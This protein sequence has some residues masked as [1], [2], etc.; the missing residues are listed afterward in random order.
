MSSLFDTAAFNQ[1]LFFPRRDVSPTPA[2]A[3][4]LRVEVGP[5]VGLH[6][7][8]HGAPGAHAMVLLFHGNG[9]VVADYDDAGAQYAELGVALAVVDYRG[10]GASDWVPTLRT[11]LA[12]AHAVRAAAQTAAGALPVV[13]MGRSLGSACAA[14]LCDGAPATSPGFIFESAIADVYGTIRR[15]G[16]HLAGPLPEADLAVFDPLRKYARCAA[17]ALVLHGERDAIIPAREAELT[18]AT[19]QSAEKTL[20]FVPDRGHND[21]SQ[22]FVYWEELDGFLAPRDGTLRP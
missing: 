21:L 16:I 11:A 17:R 18:Y 9:E 5:G 12:D 6:L 10:Y 1:S 7:R 13:V 15:R 20:A 19:L 14:E 8:V 3:R 22:G 4:D 2:G